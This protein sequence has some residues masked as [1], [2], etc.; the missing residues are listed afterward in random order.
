MCQKTSGLCITQLAKMGIDSKTRSGKNPSC[1]QT[2]A[3]TR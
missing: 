1:A 3:A 2:V